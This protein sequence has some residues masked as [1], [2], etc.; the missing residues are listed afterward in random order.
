MASATQAAPVATRFHALDALRG[1]MMLGGVVLHAFAAY[2]TVG[3]IWWMQ[4]RNRSLLVDLGLLFIHTFRLPIFFAMSGFFA[5]MLVERRGWQGF[6]ENR[7]A[8]LLLP[9]FVGM[10]A[11]A[12]LLKTM[13]SFQVAYVAG[14]P[15]W[16][17]VGAYLAT[18][19]ALRP[20]DQMHLWFLIVLFYLCLLAAGTAPWLNRLRS[21]WFRFLLTHPIV[22]IPALALPSTLI[23]TTMPMGA[24]DT[25]HSMAPHFP[26]LAAYSVY[27]AVGWGLFVNRDLLTTLRR[28]PWT[29][30]ALLVGLAPVALLA[31]KEQIEKGPNA[32]VG[33][34]VASAT[35]ALM[36]WLAFFGFL[37]LFLRYASDENPRLRYLSDAA[38]WIYVFHPVVLFPLQISLARWNLPGEV[39]GTLVSLV[40]IPILFWTY[41]YWVRHTWVGTL[42]NGRK[43]ERSQATSRQ[44]LT[45]A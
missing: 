36:S 13:R 17:A 31:V 3:D 8:R 1:I 16:P 2:A 37:A 7:S 34:L 15:V 40:A 19:N 5:A 23:L 14:Q 27:F 45:T 11:L 9:L 42:L 28:Q 21:P 22:G 18:G 44:V 4:D 38:Y 10:L 35:G 26:V 41:E 25:P 6:L 32:G 30:L 29:Y 20:L 39:K 43:F 33:L 24:L 12:P